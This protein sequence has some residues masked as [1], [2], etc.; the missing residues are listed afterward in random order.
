MLPQCVL[1]LW[2]H[3]SKMLSLQHGT[4]MWSTLCPIVKAVQQYAL[5]CSSTSQY[6][7][8]VCFAVQQ[9]LTIQCSVA[10]NQCCSH[11]SCQGDV[12]EAAYILPKS[13]ISSGSGRGKELGRGGEELISY[14]IRKM[15]WGRNKCDSVWRRGVSWGIN[16]MAYKALG[17]LPTNLWCRMQYAASRNPVTNALVSRFS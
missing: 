5:Q 15:V 3:S 12:C 7:A 16:S 14:E 8:A 9:C 17:F 1:I 2:R 4:V 11:Q 6:S 13:F 10:S